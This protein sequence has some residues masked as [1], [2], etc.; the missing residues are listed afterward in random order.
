M[1]HLG[2]PLLQ[3]GGREGIMPKFIVE[4]TLPD[5]SD[6]EVVAAARRAKEVCQ[7]LKIRWVRSYISAEERRGYCE[8]EAAGADVI[9]EHGRRTGLPVD[10]IVPVMEVDPSLFG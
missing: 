2:T 5:M 7:E 1:R 9:E 3:R 8:Y 4:R 6:E 10:R